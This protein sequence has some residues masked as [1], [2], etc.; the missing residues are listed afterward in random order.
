MLHFQKKIP[1]CINCMYYNSNGPYYS[2]CRRIFSREQPVMETHY[3][4]STIAARSYNYLC[5]FEGKFFVD[6]NK[7]KNFNISH[8]I[9]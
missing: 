3:Y 7:V 4:P 8:I 2:K 6:K 9:G 5:G 1:K